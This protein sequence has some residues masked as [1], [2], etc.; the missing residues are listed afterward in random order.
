MGLKDRYGNAVS[1]ASAEAV[2]AYD[3]G[4]EM[5]LSDIWGAGA[6]FEE[7]LAADPGFA[8]ALAGLARAQ[9]T[10]PALARQ[11]LARAEALA[12]R[13]DARERA[14]IGI[15]GLALNGRAAESRE[16]VKAHARDY[17]RDVM[18]V[19]MCGSVFG[20]IGFSGQAGREVDMLDYV[21]TLLPHYG[22]EWF[23]HTL[24]SIALCETGQ[25]DRALTLMDRSLAL[26]PRNA[27][28][29][30][31]KSHALY[32]KGDTREGRRFLDAWMEGYDRRCALH[33][34][35]S[36]HSA[37]WALYDGDTGTMWQ[38]LDEAVAPGGSQG[39]PI[40][41]LTDSAALLWRAEL[42][43]V[44]VAPERWAGLS[45][46]AA[47]FFPDPGQSFVDLHA[48]LTHAMAGQ[49]DRLARLAEKPVGFAG[50]LVPPV[51]EAFAAIARGDWDGALTALIP[52]LAQHERFGGSRAQRDILELT[53]VAALMRSGRSDEAA[54]T[55]R[56]R[57]P[58]IA[59]QL[60]GAFSPG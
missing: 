41:K 46:Y 22:D 17:P 42:A 50:D 45:D 14:H 4:V 7:A 43:G 15:L 3:R 56:L 13:L 52:A 44:P 40:N 29:A 47:Q 19:Q 18:I 39:L 24:H 32:E 38:M 25:Q 31:F 28:A 48:A 54:R 16:A 2:A 35:L 53:Y 27:N 60:A 10:E 30:H 58:V 5:F 9:A 51:A 23:I 36:W 21:A 20:L 6:V 8:M 37:L 1:T 49:G 34:H 33:G 57:R 26:N 59:P 55:L 11:T 12:D